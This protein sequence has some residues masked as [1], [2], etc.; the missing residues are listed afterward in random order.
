MKITVAWQKPHT[1]WGWLLLSHHFVV[2]PLYLP[3]FLALALVFP[4]SWLHGK[5]R[6]ALW[7]RPF[8]QLNFWAWNVPVL[9]LYLLLIPLAW[10]SNSLTWALSKLRFQRQ[11]DP[12]GA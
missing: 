1:W 9:L 10:Y 12:K 7:E 11:P 2:I 8:N 4:Y 5:S 3:G 6:A